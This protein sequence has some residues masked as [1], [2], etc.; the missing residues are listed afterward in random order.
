[1]RTHTR[2][3]T[4]HGLDGDPAEHWDKRAACRD[5]PEAFF[6]ADVHH[7][8]WAPVA[9]L[10]TCQY[11]CPVIAQCGAYAQALPTTWRTSVVLGGV[12]YDSR[13]EP[14]GRAQATRTC[15]RCQNFTPILGAEPRKHGTVAAIRWHAASGQPLCPECRRADARRAATNARARAYRA[16]ARAAAM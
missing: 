9:A 11:H 1:M 15:T 7:G 14:N 6:A 2:T 16:A 10:H 8:P 4:Q 13:G 3:R 12:A 5:T